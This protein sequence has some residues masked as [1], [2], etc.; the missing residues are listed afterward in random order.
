MSLALLPQV[1]AYRDQ[2]DIAFRYGPINI[3]GTGSTILG[4]VYQNY[5]SLPPIQQNPGYGK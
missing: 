3:S 2:A 4:N 1:D 5:Y